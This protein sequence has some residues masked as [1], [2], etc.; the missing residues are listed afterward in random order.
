M[1]LTPGRSCL[2]GLLFD[3]ELVDKKSVDKN[4]ITSTIDLIN[5]VTINYAHIEDVKIVMLTT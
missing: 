2:G 3:G 1:V 5:E 4:I